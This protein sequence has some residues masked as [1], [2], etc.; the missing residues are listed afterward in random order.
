MV[1]GKTVAPIAV[2]VKYANMV[3]FDTFALNAGVLVYA[4]IR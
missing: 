4:C 3:K 2:A 1:A